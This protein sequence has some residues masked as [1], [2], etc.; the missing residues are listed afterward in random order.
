M[1]LFSKIKNMFS[2]DKE[3][4]VVEIPKEEKVELKEEQHEETKE[5]VVESKIGRASCRERV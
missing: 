1:G 2:Q 4:N 5:E 3:E